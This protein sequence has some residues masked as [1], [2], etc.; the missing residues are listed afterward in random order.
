MCYNS[1]GTLD[2]GSVVAD[3]TAGDSFGSGG[4]IAFD[5]AVYQSYG[6][7]AIDSL[8]GYFVPG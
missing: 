7:I 2:D 4:R 5:Y 1:D 3:S 8:G 6:N